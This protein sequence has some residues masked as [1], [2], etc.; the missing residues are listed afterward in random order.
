MYSYDTR[1][2]NHI[3]YSL[4]K[5]VKEHGAQSFPRGLKTLELLNCVVQFNSPLEHYL[6]KR[7][8]NIN[9]FFHFVENLWILGGRGDAKTMDYV[10]KSLREIALDEGAVEYHGAYGLR[11]LSH[12]Y[13]P[14][15]SSSNVQG[16]EESAYLNQLEDVIT[17]LSRDPETRRAVITLWNPKLDH[18]DQMSRDFPCNV[19]LSFKLRNN[20]LH[21][22]IFNRSN[23]LYRGL[24]PTNF[25]QFSTLLEYVATR[26]DVEIGTQVH[27]SNSLHI[28]FDEHAIKLDSSLDLSDDTD[29]YDFLSPIRMKSVLNQ[30]GNGVPSI[31]I[32]NDFKVLFD[33]DLET[34][35]DD[36]LPRMSEN[37]YRKKWNFNLPYFQKHEEIFTILWFKRRNLETLIKNRKDIQ[38]HD[39]A[40][41]EKDAKGDEEQQKEVKKQLSIYLQDVSNLIKNLGSYD[42]LIAALQF[43][44]RRARILDY[45]PLIEGYHDLKDNFPQEVRD[46]IY[47]HV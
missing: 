33:K 42:I 12:N 30:E 35:L 17:K 26:L 23:D 19:A 7:G 37:D 41:G 36:Y 29:L 39:L 47:Y 5:E 44:Y 2:A 10:I 32:K 6:L 21:L 38:R 45:I 28:Y 20:T 18:A 11:I 16:L 15:V 22:S 13:F 40:A 3:F 8:R 43:S 31:D 1:N 25:S 9:P 24:V 46:F 34:F 4:L 14:N 27:F